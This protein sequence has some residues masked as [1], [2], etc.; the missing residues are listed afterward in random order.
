M[1]V[2][3]YNGSLGLV[4]RSGVG[5]A[6]YHQKAMLE[7]AGVAVTESWDSHADAVHIN[8]V[9]PDAVFA[10]LRARMRGETVVYYGHSTMQD[11]RDSFVG[12]NLLAP[13]FGRWIRFC[14][15]LGDFIITPTPYSQQILESYHL[16]KPVCVLSNGVDTDFFCPRPGP[17]GAL[18][19][20]TP[21]GR[22][23]AGGG[24][25]RALL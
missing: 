19:P 21:A 20:G 16:K 13:L 11:F 17:A 10:A 4:R 14:Y 1:R 12:S 24:E 8:T 5:Q 18:P 3:L 6:F 2:H 7:Q 23:P 25:R 22:R 15:D 9:L